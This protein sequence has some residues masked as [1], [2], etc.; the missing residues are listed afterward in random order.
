MNKNETK[1]D[2]RFHLDSANWLSDEVKAKVKEKMPHELTKDGL[3]VVK[4]DRDASSRQI[5]GEVKLSQAVHK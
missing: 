5:S 2:I 3:F 1:V 4:S